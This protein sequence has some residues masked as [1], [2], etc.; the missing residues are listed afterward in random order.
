MLN[1][2]LGLPIGHVTESDAPWVYIGELGLRLVHVDIAKGL[3]VVANRFPPGY[4]VQPHH[5]TGSVYALTLSGRWRYLEYGI[6]YC[7]GSYIHEPAG[8]KHTLH[9]PADNDGL[10]EVFFVIEGANLN[11]DEDGNVV[12]ITDASSIQQAYRAI[13]A[14]QGLTAGHLGS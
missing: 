11:L 6:D 7:A 8:S 2:D 1:T 4:T 3:W 14:A 13:C 10:T 9:V 5:H 12:S